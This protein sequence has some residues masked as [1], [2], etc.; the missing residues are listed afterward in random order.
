MLLKNNISS[1]MIEVVDNNQIDRE[2]VKYRPKLVVVEALW[3]VPEKFEVLQK[4]HPTVKWFVRLHSEIP[5]LAQEGVAV[6]WLKGY[7][8][9]N[10]TITSNSERIIESFKGI[11]KNEIEYL[12]NYYQIKHII[13]N[14]EFKPETEL[15]I[16][17]FGAIRPFKNHLYQALAAMKVANHNKMK[18]RFHINA[19]RK[20]QHGE[21]VFKNL[22]GLFEE[23]DHEL[24][25]VPWLCHDEFLRYIKRYINIGMQV[26]FTETF[27]IVAA[28]HIV[29]NTPILTSSEVKFVTS[30][31]HADPNDV[32]DMA[33]KLNRIYN[34]NFAGKVLNREK[35][36][37]S[38]FSARNDWLDFVEHH[39]KCQLRA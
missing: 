32:T 24:V 5:F 25:E 3:V 38:N 14:L 34:F 17:C 18:L 27:C 31:Y 8:K 20:E 7:E 21:N 13:G 39:K 2:L 19:T 9:H 15:N 28:D 26:S 30:F 33:S 37:M 10:V 11:L 6:S 12:P 16:S 36:R 22:R 35:L 29:T 1:N 23:T 4:L